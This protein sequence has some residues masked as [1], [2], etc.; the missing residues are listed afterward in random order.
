MYSPAEI[1]TTTTKKVKLC[2]DNFQDTWD[3]KIFKTL[4][5][6]Q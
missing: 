5:V 2:W 6:R 1:T 4:D 3:I